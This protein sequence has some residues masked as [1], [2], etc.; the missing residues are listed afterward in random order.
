MEEHVPQLC[1]RE[2]MRGWVLAGSR[3]H[4]GLAGRGFGH[5]VAPPTPLNGNNTPLGSPFP[6]QEVFPFIEANSVLSS[7]ATQRKSLE[8]KSF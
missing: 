5:R 4:S 6:F 1:G 8:W 3:N 2:E 7:E